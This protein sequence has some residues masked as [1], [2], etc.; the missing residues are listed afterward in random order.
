MDEFTAVTTVRALT[1]CDFF[2]LDAE[3]FQET[4]SEF[5]GAQAELQRAAIR[6]ACL[7]AHRMLPAPWWRQCTA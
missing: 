4:I 6:R 3:A 5:P 2:V 1:N 7:H